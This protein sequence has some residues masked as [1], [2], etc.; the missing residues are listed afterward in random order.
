MLT[1]DHYET[2]T[3]VILR[4]PGDL[5]EMAGFFFSLKQGEFIHALNSRKV[6]WP[7]YWRILLDLCR[8]RT[9]LL[10]PLCQSAVRELGS[11]EDVPLK[12]VLE[13][14]FAETPVRFFVARL[15]LCVFAPFIDL[16]VIINFFPLCKPSA[17]LG[18]GWEEE[19][20]LRTEGEWTD[21]SQWRKQREPGARAGFQ[22]TT[23]RAAEARPRC[24]PWKRVY[25]PALS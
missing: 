11:K 12:I 2:F 1:A 22:Q 6:S 14:I 16:T 24:H 19:R 23:W 3:W 5:C 18:N 10:F 20:C 15:S 8:N 7:L 21:G 4:A 9:H 25:G 17:F 13:I